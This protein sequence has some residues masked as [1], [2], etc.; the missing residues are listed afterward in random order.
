MPRPDI[1]EQGSTTIVDKFGRDRRLRHSRSLS[2]LQRSGSH[3]ARMARSDVRDPEMW[4]H[5]NHKKR[6]VKPAEITYILDIKAD[7]EE[8]SDPMGHMPVLDMK[9]RYP[10]ER[11]DSDRPPPPPPKDPVNPNDGFRT[12]VKA[13]MD[14]SL[15]T[16]GEVPPKPRKPKTMDFD[17]IAHIDP[18]LDLLPPNPTYDPERRERFLASIERER[19]AEM[20]A[21]EA[22]RAHASRENREKGLAKFEARDRQ[23]RGE[24]KTQERAEADRLAK[25]DLQEKTINAKFEE[26][27]RQIREMEREQMAK[28]ELHEKTFKEKEALLRAPLQRSASVNVAPLRGMPPAKEV[29]GSLGTS[30]ARFWSPF[31]NQ[32]DENRSRAQD[33]S[34]H[35]RLISNPTTLTGSHGSKMGLEKD[36][37]LRDGPTVHRVIVQQAKVV[38]PPP[39]Q[40]LNVRPRNPSID[41]TAS[42]RPL[43]IRPRNPSLDSTASR[44]TPFVNR[45]IQQ[46]LRDPSHP[47][48]REPIPVHPVHLVDPEAILQDTQRPRQ[49]KVSLE[50][51]PFYRDPS[52]YIRP[53]SHARNQSLT[54]VH[55]TPAADPVYRS[56]ESSSH[57]RN[58]SSDYHH[59][60]SRSRNDSSASSHNPPSYGS[61]HVVPGYEFPRKK[62]HEGPPPSPSQR[63][64]EER[65]VK[66]KLPSREDVFKRPHI[67]PL[68]GNSHLRV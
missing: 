19:R 32:E 35:K 10:S 25:R 2:E 55:S 27:D 63:H 45:S 48:P 56:T 24:K 17:S 49:F 18:G 41:S 40:P 30:H 6:H 62:R 60:P 20:A 29:Q 21:L 14:T 46:R 28:R 26:R 64:R 31:A 47:A 39:T 23:I 66:D 42:T 58:V 22:A 43:N 50:T 3:P 15:Q 1:Y 68:R 54:S 67:E 36:E 34:G 12:F 11:R 13:V 37:R 59:T 53:L 61:T 16:P 52:G 7:E 51:E 38:D 44:V 8:S 9:P 5:P 33:H 4:A 65:I 57:A